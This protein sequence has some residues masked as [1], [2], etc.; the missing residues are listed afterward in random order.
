MKLIFVIWFIPGTNYNMILVFFMVLTTYLVQFEGT[1]N[2][3]YLDM[4]RLF[5]H[6][7]WSDY[8]SKRSNFHSFN[9]YFSLLLSTFQLFVYMFIMLIV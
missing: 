3:K 2:S 9:L 4:L 6:G 7:T 1:E 5:A 8:K